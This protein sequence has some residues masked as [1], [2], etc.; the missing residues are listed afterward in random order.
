M[1]SGLVLFVGGIYAFVS[2]DQYLRGNIPM[3]IAWA[4]Y[5]FANIGLAMKVS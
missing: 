1:S 2:V 4:G 3:A 5:A